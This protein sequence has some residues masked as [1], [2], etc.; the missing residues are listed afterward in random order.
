M[1]YLCVGRRASIP[2]YIDTAGIGLYSA[3]ELAYY[4]KENIMMLDASILDESLC[5]FIEKELMLPELADTLRECVMSGGSLTDFVEALMS[6]TN[7]AGKEEIENMKRQLAARG[8]LSKSEKHRMKG[9]FLVKG[10]RYSEAV[11]EYNMALEE[12]DQ[13]QKP[14]EA[15][16]IYHNKG[17]AYADLFYFAEAAECFR[18]AFE[19][20]PTSQSSKEAFS[21]ARS[22]AEG[23]IPESAASGDSV[24]ERRYRRYLRKVEDG[25]VEGSQVILTELLNDMENS[26]RKSV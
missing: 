2:Y 7:L 10:G 11:N 4:V 12:I 9:D 16:R 19:L 18:L 15:A 24:M 6:E 20:N 3:E 23:N 17:V 21:D 26:Y 1:V 22:L 5:K 14:N 13:T 25:D 8:T